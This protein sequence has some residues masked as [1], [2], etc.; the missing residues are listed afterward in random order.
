MSCGCAGYHDVDIGYWIKW[1]QD[2]QDS[3]KDD[4]KVALENYMAEFFNNFMLDAIYSESTETITLYRA[5]EEN[6]EDDNGNLIAVTTLLDRLYPIGAIIIRYDDSD[7]SEFL[8]VGTWEIVDDGYCLMS[9][10]SDDVGTMGEATAITLTTS[11]LP[12]HNHNISV[13]SAGSHTHTITVDSSGAHTHTVT[14]ES[15]GEHTHE[16]TIEYAYTG[17]TGSDATRIVNNDGTES[18]GIV[19]IAD[20]GSHTHSASTASAGSHTHSATNANAGSHT[21]TATADNT[22][23]GEGFTIDDSNMARMYVA[24]WKRIA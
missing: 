7:P 21:H 10:D 24:V 22:G 20:A 9:G 4:F 15:A 14:I 23:G 19:H 8:G 12:S 3:Q 18:G 6:I 13:D 11:N 2:F 5:V 1:I 17:T 16:A